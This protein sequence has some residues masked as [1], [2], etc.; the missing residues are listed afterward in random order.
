MNN[1]GSKTVLIVDNGLFVSLAQTLARRFGKVLYYS[2]WEQSFPRSND[3]LVGYGIP[4]VTR[5]DS[6]WPVIDDVD[7]F[8]FPDIF[9][10]PLQVY[11]RKQGKR[12]WGSGIGENL[13]IIRGLFK[14]LIRS[15]GLEVG[16]FR[17]IR[18]L[19][20]L[21][22]FLKDNDD[23]YVKISRTRG[24]METFHA[25]TY[26]LIEPRLDQLEHMLGAKK[27]IQEFIV[28]APIA[29]AIEVGYDGYTI[30][31]KYP[32]TALY[33]VEIKDTAYLGQVVPYRQ[34]PAGVQEVNRRLAGMFNDW[35]YRGFWSSE[36]RIKGGKPYLIDPCCRMASP[37]GELYQMM[38]TNLADVLWHGAM[39]DLVEPEFS[40]TWGAQ[41]VMRSSWTEKE[42]AAVDF[43][44]S[45][46]DNVKLSY[47]TRI[48]G[49]NYFIPQPVE[50]AE[51]GS[52]VATGSSPDDAIKNVTK[53]AEKVE[54]YGLKFNFEALEDAKADME[55][56]KD[57]A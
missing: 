49:R 28:E 14:R 13:E 53:I 57:A 45:I 31:G 6:I 20:R 30:D 19:D 51:F 3:T 7:L 42:W 25:P 44:A 2:P 55:K 12:V 29:P 1:F 9:H 54:A 24:D 52:V 50:M 22:D 46:A 41:I 43:P 26:K 38:I 15:A 34:L 17:Q 11:L 18:G 39:G 21:R 10:G 48:Q 35:T 40:D 32:Q 4:G 27:H 36:I 33:G 47:L 37:P 5:V 16:P 8:V 23:H 56:L